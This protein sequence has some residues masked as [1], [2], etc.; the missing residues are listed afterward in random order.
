M[1]VIM[2]EKLTKL[3]EEALKML[4]SALEIDKHRGTTTVQETKALH[5]LCKKGHA[6]Y[7][8]GI[9]TLKQDMK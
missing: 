5:R 3:E 9:W 2:A 7:R 6:N 1:G 8:A 4:K